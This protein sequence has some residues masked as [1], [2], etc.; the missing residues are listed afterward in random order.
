MFVLGNLLVALANV[1]S[2][3]L[4]IFYWILLIRALISWV[5]LSPYNPIVQFLYK[6]TEPVLEPVRRFL[7]FQ[8]KTGIDISPLIVFLMVLFLR[9][10]IVQTLLDL[11][12]RLK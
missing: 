2:I 11:A 7:P 6:V 3:F 5:N 12:Y 9:S 8:L 10:F 4:T 1:L